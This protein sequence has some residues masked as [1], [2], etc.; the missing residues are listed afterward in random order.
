MPTQSWTGAA[1]EPLRIL[2]V[3]LCA[4]GLTRALV[5]LTRNEDRPIAEAPSDDDDD[6]PAWLRNEDMSI[7]T[8]HGAI[9]PLDEKALSEDDQVWRFTGYASI[10]GSKDLGNDVVV[11]GAFAKSLREHGMPLLLFQHKH[12]E[13]PVGTVVEAREDRRGLYIKGELP[14]DDAFCRDRLVP[15]LKRRGLKGMSIGYRA[16]ETEKRKSD[17]AR[18]LKQI[19]LYECSF[20]SMPMHPA[21]G[22]ETIKHLST[23]ELAEALEE[24]TRAARQLTEAARPDPVAELASATKALSAFVREARR[25]RPQLRDPIAKASIRAAQA[26]LERLR[27]EAS[28]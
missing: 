17:G 12:D 3:R 25:D 9:V 11:E 14:K 28:R 10:F 6:A 22:V 23:N 4:R 26:R 24:F 20:V 13:C 18:L 5:Y 15:Q 21:A 2:A 27:D 7:E 16:L 8:K 1:V 19:R